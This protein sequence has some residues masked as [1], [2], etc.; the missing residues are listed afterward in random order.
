MN[1]IFKYSLV[2]IGLLTYSLSYAQQ[3]PVMN[4]YIYNPYLYNPARTGQNTLGSVY[5]N[6][7]K[8]WVG[9]S[10]SPITGVLSA[11]SPILGNSKN[12]GIG[13]M[14]YTDQMHILSKIGGMA[15]YA[16]H[17]N[18]VKNKDYFHRLS[19]GLSVGVLNQRFNFAAA[20][21]YTDF[22][23]QIVPKNVNGTSFDFSAGI[24]YQ[25]RGL[26]VG[27]SMLQGL[28]NSMKFINPGDTNDITFINSR[29]FIFTASYRHNFGKSKNHLYIEPVFLGRLVDGL[30]FQ[31]EGNIVFGMKNI[32]FIGVGYRSSNTETATSALSF[33][34]GVE[35]NS[36][37]MAAYTMDMGID[38]SLN[39]SLGMQHEFMLACKI[40]KDDSKLEQELERLR[41]EDLKLQESMLT[42]EEQM[43]KELEAQKEAAANK[44]QELQ[45]KIQNL[46]SEADDLR[47]KVLTNEKEI[48]ELKKRLDDLNIAQKQI[49]EIFFDSESDKLSKDAKTNLNTLKTILDSYPKGIV[50]YLFGNASTD[51]DAKYNMELAVRRGA[52]VRNYLIEKGCN[53]DKIYIIPMGEYN[54]MSGNPNKA[55]KRDRRIDIMVSQNNS[56]Y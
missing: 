24:D 42:K 27:A 18:F 39:N 33:T 49:G 7:K 19:V 3:L 52:A 5:A 28:N 15:S 1:T 8:Q 30:P 21:L 35:I 20:N 29:H 53:T 56:K 38:K 47:S 45:G 32:G 50:V 48:Q 26:H 13:G 14:I 2:V 55:E 36:R 54:P 41:K 6:F 4:H 44:E 10:Q 37:V 25:F 40:G 31:A 34:G 9:M 17:I 12:M 46:N 51:G 16:Y 43:N 22:D 11:E 23:P